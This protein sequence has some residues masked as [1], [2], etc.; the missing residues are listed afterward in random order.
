MAFEKER[1]GI[2]LWDN[3]ADALKAAANPIS[4]YASLLEGWRAAS[5]AAA[6]PAGSEGGGGT[7]L[8]GQQAMLRMT[9]LAVETMRAMAAPAA[10]A[11]DAQAPLERSLSEFREKIAVNPMLGGLDLW[12]AAAAQFNE[13]AGPWTQLMQQSIGVAQTMGGPAGAG[14][15]LGDALERSFGVMASFPGLDSELPTLLRDAA[16]NA[17]ALT[18]A[19]EGYRV[20]MAATWQRA[21]EEIARDLVR[22]AADGKAVDSPGALLSLSTSVADRVFV[23]TFNS[24]RYIEAQQRLSTALADQRRN[25][26]KVVDLFAGLGHFPTRRDHDEL[27]RE[28]ATLRRELRALKRTVRAFGAAGPP[29]AAAQPWRNGA[30]ASAGSD[31]TPQTKKRTSAKTPRAAGAAPKKKNANGE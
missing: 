7:L 18:S 26:A 8:G 3:W 1:T 23:E 6:S 15:P 21:F 24:A 14:D 5:G 20:I 27:I 31:S 13:L 28:I 10:S 29:A 30:V 12:A 16:A 11:A 19:R 17:V 9:E 22:R 2:P 4:A 25:E